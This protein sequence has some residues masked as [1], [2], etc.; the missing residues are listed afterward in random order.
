MRFT[1]LCSVRGVVT[2]SR[3][4]ASFAPLDFTSLCFHKT[5]LLCTLIKL[6][7]FNR[8]PSGANLICNTFFFH[9]SHSWKRPVH[10]WGASMNSSEQIPTFD[11]YPSANGSYKTVSKFILQ[12]LCEEQHD[13]VLTDPALKYIHCLWSAQY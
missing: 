13:P 2:L 10:G 6:L 1:P 3:N 7:G 11:Y 8:P 12:V 5:S 9:L 4:R